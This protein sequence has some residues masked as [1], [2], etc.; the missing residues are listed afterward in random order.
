MRIAHIAPE[1]LK[2]DEAVH[3][4]NLL[5]NHGRI[6]KLYI[7]LTARFF[8]R[9][10]ACDVV[11]DLMRKM[12]FQLAETFSIPLAAAK[13]SK[14]LFTIFSGWI[15]LRHQVRYMQ[16]VLRGDSSGAW[17]AESRIRAM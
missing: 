4:P 5:A 8:R 2:K 14:S 17:S 1:I 12:R 9:H 15:R 3:L 6:A 13:E 16:Q 10:A 7:S 11:V